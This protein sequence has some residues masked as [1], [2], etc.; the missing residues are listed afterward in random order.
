[1]TTAP[2]ERRAKTRSE[3][4]Y[5]QVRRDILNGSLRPG[6]KLQGMF[7]ANYPDAALARARDIAAK[8][9]K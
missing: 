1:M 6:E 9:T 8:I 2:T 4:V 3:A 5:T 7:N